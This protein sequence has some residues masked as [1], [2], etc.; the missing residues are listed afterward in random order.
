MFGQGLA[1]KFRV[2]T[3]Q[4]THPYDE[5]QKAPAESI[6]SVVNR[7]IKFRPSGELCQALNCDCKSVKFIHLPNDP[8]AL[9]AVPS[10]DRSL[11]AVIAQSNDREMLP[12][13]DV[14]RR[15]WARS[16]TN[17]AWKVLDAPDV[18]ALC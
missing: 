18:L 5:H 4:R 1:G 11:M 13:F 3:R 9:L 17:R 7:R 10:E 6:L 12:L 8:R 15:T 14:M 2:R 16:I